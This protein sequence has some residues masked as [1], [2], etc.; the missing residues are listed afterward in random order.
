MRLTEET[1]RHAS[2]TM[3]E[4]EDPATDYPAAIALIR[5]HCDFL[6]ESDKD[7]ILFRTAEDFFF[8]R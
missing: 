4:M 2:I 8:N 6:S 7:Y 5:D 1:E 3:I